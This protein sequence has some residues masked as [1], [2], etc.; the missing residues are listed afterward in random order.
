[1]FEDTK[2]VIRSLKSKKNRIAKRKTAKGQAMIT[3]LYRNFFI[4]LNSTNTN[5]N[6]VNPCAPVG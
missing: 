6:G 2:M 3:K 4:I 5:K 1:M